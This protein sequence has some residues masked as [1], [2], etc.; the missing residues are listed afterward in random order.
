MSPNIVFNGIPTKKQRFVIYREMLENYRKMY[1]SRSKKFE[2]YFPY[3]YDF[4]KDA[5]TVYS[6]CTILSLS[7]YSLYV[8]SDIVNYPELMEWKPVNRKAKTPWFPKTVEGLITRM[9]ILNIVLK[10]K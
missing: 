4:K 9:L 8:N 5:G 3:R 10:E 6:L 1:F 7:N 2:D